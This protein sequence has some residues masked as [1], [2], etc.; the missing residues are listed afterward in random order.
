MQIPKINKTAIY[1]KRCIY[2]ILIITWI[3]RI[4][5]RSVLKQDNHE[6]LNKSLTIF[7]FILF[8]ISGLM[9]MEANTHLAS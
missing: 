2:E 8:S 9:P 1:E 5:Y 3:I 6:G 7:R 4:P